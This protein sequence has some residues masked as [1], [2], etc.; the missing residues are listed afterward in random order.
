[1]NGRAAVRIAVL[2][3]VWCVLFTASADAQAQDEAQLPVKVFILAGQSNMEGKAK[4]SLLEKQIAA[5][6]TRERFAHL[7]RDGDWIKRSDVF[8]RFLDRSGPLTV[9]YGSP[10]RIGPELDFGHSTGDHFE[11]PVLIIKTAWGGK[12]LFRDFRP[13]SAG[14]PGPE[15]LEKDLER[16]RKRKP[17]T[18][19]A[20]IRDS[21][22]VFYRQMLHQVEDTLANIDQY[23]PDYDDRGYELAGLVWFQGWNDMVNADYT[24]AYTDNLV[25]F[26][27]DVRRDLQQPQLPVVIGQLGVGGTSRPGIKPNPKRDTFKAAQAAAADTAEFRGSVVVVRTDAFWDLDAEAVFAKGWKDHQEEWE[28]VGSDYPF[29][30]LGS[31]KTYSDI[32]RAFAEAII[33]LD[34]ASAESDSSSSE[35]SSH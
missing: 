6:E 21:Y 29:H 15:V 10:D 25:H 11:Q 1:M 28:Q 31:A 2:L 35:T 5:P 7:H 24:A 27:R 19:L 18:T 8:I 4:V 17:D 12:S 26:I 9:G 13:P 3:V 33:A 34:S 22:G 14:L 23:V 16:A 20:D 30:Y 32:G